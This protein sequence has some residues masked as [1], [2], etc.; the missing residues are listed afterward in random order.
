MHANIYSTN[1]I[2]GYKKGQEKVT[3]PLSW[4]CIS[5]CTHVNLGRCIWYLREKI[6]ILPPEKHLQT[7][8][9]AVLALFWATE[10][11]WG[12]ATTR[13]YSHELIPTQ[14]TP[15]HFT[16]ACH[17][18]PKTR[19]SYMHAPYKLSQK[20]CLQPDM[21]TS[22]HITQKMWKSCNLCVSLWYRWTM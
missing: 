20:S 14:S 19:S 4:K 5:S 12:S 11:H 17:F 3:W 1:R 8:C 10:P 9:Q 15:L 7:S 2:Y 16:F 13:N 22:P 21:I 6:C 18:N